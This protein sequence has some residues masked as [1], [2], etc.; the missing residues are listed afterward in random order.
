MIKRFAVFFFLTLVLTLVLTGCSDQVLDG[1][2]GVSPPPDAGSDISPIPGDGDATPPPGEGDA[3][4]VEDASGQPPSS[5]VES[6]EDADTARTP[7]DA[8]TPGDE[9][10]GAQDDVGAAGNPEDAG[11][12]PV[13]CARYRARANLSSPGASA[14]W[15]WG[16]GVGYPDRLAPEPACT[17][18]VR[19]RRQLIDALANAAPGG[20]VY[21]R[22]D[23]RIDLSGESL[24]I[25]K[26]VWLAGGRGHNHSPGGLIYSSMLT[27]TPVLKVC[28]AGVRITGLRIMGPD[29]GQC[30][31]EYPNQCERTGTNCRDCKPAAVG[32]RNDRYDDTEIDNNELSGWSHGAIY[33]RGGSGHQ[34]HHNDIHHNQRQGLG[35]GVVLYAPQEGA[36]DV[37]VE[38]NRFDYNRHAIAGSGFTGQDYT[39]HDNLVLPN[40]NGHVF[41]MHGMNER[42]SDGS[43]GAGGAILIHDNIVLTADQYAL[44]VRGRPAHGAWLYANCLA[45]RSPAEAALQRFFTGNFYVDVGPDGASANRYGQRAQDCTPLRW[46]YAAGGA[47]PWA[48]LARASDPLSGLRVGDFDGD[49]KTDVFRVQSGE[50]QWSR[51]GTGSWARLQSSNAAPAEL[52]LGDFDG[53]GKTDV[54]WA[55]GTQWRFSPGATGAWQP[56]RGNRER[57]EQLVFGDFNGDGKTD[58]F[59]TSGGKWWVSWGATSAWRELNASAVQRKDLG[60][61]DFDGDGKTDVFRTG[62]GKWWVSRSG[63]GSWQALKDSN[64]SLPSL[65]LADVDGDGKTDVVRADGST[66]W[67]SPAG[68][69]AWQRVRDSSLDIRTLPIGDFNGDGVPDVFQAQC[70]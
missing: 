14:S 46:C 10:G 5:D 54:F 66:W 22:D 51:S 67:L 57:L 60:F 11:Q 70:L 65:R 12:P 45:Q 20:I 19:T 62:S 6:R 34:V 36:V 42:L 4:R 52:Y 30:P 27:T 15:R 13:D 69:G 64:V 40:A 41:D 1:S 24:C 28:G 50:W 17:T 53:D 37:I 33:L 23:A 29:P 8:G 47:G 18:Q 26:D 48:Y 25:K 68:Q 55:N 21:V 39:A 63:T 44:V 16:G 2:N 3:G 32:I 43:P 61:G 38:A 31:A 56:L 7:D 59:K 9:D 58:V 35:Y 49:G